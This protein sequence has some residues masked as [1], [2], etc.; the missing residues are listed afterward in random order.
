VCACVPF[1]IFTD[2]QGYANPTSTNLGSMEAVG[3]GPTPGTCFIARRVEVVP[4]A[5]LLLISWCV[6]GEPDFSLFFLF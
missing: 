6:S 3:G 4:V 1:V 2:Y 5:G